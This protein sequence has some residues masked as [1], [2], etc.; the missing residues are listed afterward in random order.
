HNVVAPESILLKTRED[1]YA[2]S[3]FLQ[4]KETFRLIKQLVNLAM[5]RL[6]NENETYKEDMDLLFKHMGDRYR[7]D[8]RNKSAPSFVKRDLDAKNMSE[9][10]RLL[11]PV[12]KGEKLDGFVDCSL[13]APYEDKSRYG[14]L[15][16]SQSFACFQS[17]ASGLVSIVLPFDSVGSVEKDPRSVFDDT[18]IFQMTQGSSRTTHFKFTNI[19]KTGVLV[20]KF[21]SLVKRYKAK[22]RFT[23]Q[24][25]NNSLLSTEERPG[26]CEEEG[27]K[28]LLDPLM[29]LFREE[30]TD[31]TLEAQK[32]MQ[33]Q[34]YIETYGRGVSMYRTK[35]LTRLVLHGIPNR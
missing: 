31:L 25:N 20:E 23:L 5:R 15:Y 16:I 21:N 26:R 4:K 2:F 24:E 11:F 32:E 3:M 22:K 34:K 7:R 28:E 12:P 27:D 35:D 17:H 19:Q 10:Y 1:S 18:I 9:Q 33:C 30:D 6:I 8:G 14:K 29:N 13:W